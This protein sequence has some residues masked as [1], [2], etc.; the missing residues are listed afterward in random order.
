MIRE[1]LN[2]REAARAMAK[3]SKSEER[4]ESMQHHVFVCRG[5]SCSKAGS[6]V[7]LAVMRE[8]VARHGLEMTVRITETNCNLRCSQSPIMMVYPDGV[9]YQRTTPETAELV[10]SQHLIEGEPVSAMSTYRYIDGRFQ[11]FKAKQTKKK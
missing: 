1:V 4:M 3:K 7:V 11:P 9:W 8:S 10:V 2:C 5:E 6:E